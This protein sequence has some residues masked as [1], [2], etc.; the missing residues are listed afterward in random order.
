MGKKSLKAR[1]A[2]LSKKVALLSQNRLGVSAY[3]NRF[4]TLNFLNKDL[5][6]SCIFS[7]TKVSELCKNSI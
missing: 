3:S 7:Q 1:K 5:K 4:C 2:R 6:K